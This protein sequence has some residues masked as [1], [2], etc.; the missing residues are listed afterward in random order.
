MSDIQYHMSM[1]QS[2]RTSRMLQAAMGAKAHGERIKIL[3]ASQVNIETC[4]NMKGIV[5][6]GMAPLSPQ[7]FITLNG[8]A[9]MASLR[10]Q[11]S[12]YVD[13][14]AW[15]AADDVMKDEI[16]YVDA[17]GALKGPKPWPLTGWLDEG[18][19]WGTLEGAVAVDGPVCGWQE[20]RLC[21]RVDGHEGKH[22]EC[23]PR[24]AVEGPWEAEKAV[25]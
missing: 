14:F 21:G 25:L 16:R 4:L 9:T 6:P 19:E 15:E 8:A 1:R 17:V 24:E 18:D 2:G 5:H 23:S 7:D 11:R 13:H 12:V 22:W 10:G 3:V 20:D